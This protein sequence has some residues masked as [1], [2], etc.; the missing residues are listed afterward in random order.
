[1][2]TDIS[3]TDIREEKCV[4]DIIVNHFFTCVCLFYSSVQQSGC[5][6]VWLY[7]KGQLSSTFK[8]VAFLLCQDSLAVSCMLRRSRTGDKV[9]GYT[10]SG[11]EP[12]KRPHLT[13][14]LW[15]SHM[16]NPIG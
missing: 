13:A 12:T 16:L 8:M 6:K 7:L 10:D 9:I 1:V 3:H 11:T 5:A 4:M 14:E 15:C 2:R